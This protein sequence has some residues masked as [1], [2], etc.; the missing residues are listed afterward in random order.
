MNLGN[1]PCA[2]IS[3]LLKIP[4]KNHAVSLGD[5]LTPESLVIYW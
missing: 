2:C 1:L 3:H 4:M 5:D